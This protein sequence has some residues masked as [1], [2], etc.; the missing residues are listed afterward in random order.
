[1]KTIQTFDEL[2]QLVST[3]GIHRRI[4]AVNPEDEATCLTLRQAEE[5]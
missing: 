2:R 3:N 1:M 4:V 5:E